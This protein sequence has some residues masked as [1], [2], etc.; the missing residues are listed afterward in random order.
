MATES[1]VLAALVQRTH[2]GSIRRSACVFLSQYRWRSP[3]HQIIFEVLMAIPSE[4]IETIRSQLPG[5]LT[6]MGFPDFDWEFL[7]T[8]PRLSQLEAQRLIANLAR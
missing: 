8:M 2:E 6:R 5:R 3:A 1:K 4:N 7:F